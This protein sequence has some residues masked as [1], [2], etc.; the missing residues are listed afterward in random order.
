MKFK[1]TLISEGESVNIDSINCDAESIINLINKYSSSDDIFEKN[2]IVYDDEFRPLYEKI[3]KHNYLNTYITP[4]VYDKKKFYN[5]SI[6]EEEL[7]EI[8]TASSNIELVSQQKELEIYTALQE[9]MYR[10]NKPGV[11]QL[12]YKDLLKLLHEGGTSNINL[13][14]HESQP[15]RKCCSPFYTQ[16][17][18]IR[19]Q[20]Y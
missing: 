13:N 11:S 18:Y 9:K 8:K 20:E 19:L 10:Q 4:I 12:T 7:K 2:A 3:K 1:I 17:T 15:R 14:Q 6:S 5:A 16:N